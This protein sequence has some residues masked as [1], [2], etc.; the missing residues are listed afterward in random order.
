MKQNAAIYG[1][2]SL[3]DQSKFSL[4]SQQKG[5]IEL[6]AQ[7]GFSV[8]Q[9]FRFIDNGGSSTE[10]D[11]P[12]LTALREA[13]RSSVVKAVFIFHPD[14]L[15]R[16]FV[17]QLLLVEEDFQK[18]GIVAERFCNMPTD[19]TPEGELLFGMLGLVTVELEKERIRERTNARKPRTREARVWRI[20]AGYGLKQEC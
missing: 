17:H 11:R 15:S 5:C 19:Q 4:P 6:A 14:R 20:T 2:I 9:Q 18:A 8:P 7:R 12:G 3:E 16:K 10:L 1:R 13:V